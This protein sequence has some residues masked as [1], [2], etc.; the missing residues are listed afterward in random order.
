[1]G[2]L[3]PRAVKREC[4]A[5]LRKRGMRKAMVGIRLFS[6]GLVLLLEDCV[7]ALEYVAIDIEY[8]G[9]EGEIKRH[10]LREL[11]KRD[12]AIKKDQITFRRIG[13]GSAAHGLAWRTYRGYRA[14]DR[15]ITVGELLAAC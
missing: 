11:R 8:V 15:R 2:I 5:R 9:G 6:A 13:K 7:E 14:P 3:I 10:L 4:Y 1:M 12:H